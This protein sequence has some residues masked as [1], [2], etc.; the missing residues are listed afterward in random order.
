MT[1]REAL[2]EIAATFAVLCGAGLFFTLCW[3]ATP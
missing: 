2:T 1:A 3:I